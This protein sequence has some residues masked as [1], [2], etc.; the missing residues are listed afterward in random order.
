MGFGELKGQTKAVEIIQTG[1]RTGRIAHA[2]M[3]YG[4]SGVGKKKAAL[5]FAQGLN[6]LRT[7]HND[8]CGI[9]QSCSKIAAGNHPDITTIF[10]EGNSIKIT[11]IRGLQEKAFFKCYEGNYK[12]IIIDEAD[13]LTI[14]AANSLLKILE[15]PPEQTVF[16]LLAE[17]MGKLPKTIISRC[18]PIPFLPLE[19]K[20]IQNILIEL[21]MNSNF[22]LGLA[23]GSVGKAIEIQKNEDNAKIFEDIEKLLYDLRKGGYKKVLS[24]AEAFD[25]NKEQ[26]EIMLEILSLYYRDRIVSLAVGDTNLLLDTMAQKDYRIEECYAALHKLNNAVRMIKNNINTRLVLDVLFIDLRNIEQNN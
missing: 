14:E 15:E 20:D 7:E 18:Q 11:Q 8:P 13:K 24:W 23:Y 17:D 16:I 21:G 12:V 2:Y 26:M 6:C 25:K 19:T 9:C 4:P 3:F 22:P 10:T 5:L 1:L